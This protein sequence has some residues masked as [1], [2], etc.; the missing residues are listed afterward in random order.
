MLQVKVINDAFVFFLTFHEL[1]RK[2][3]LIDCIRIFN[4][5][6]KFVTFWGYKIWTVSYINCMVGE[7]CRRMTFTGY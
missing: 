4:V 1:A 5:Y 3:E 6:R 7:K 2:Y